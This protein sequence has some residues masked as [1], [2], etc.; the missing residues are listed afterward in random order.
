MYIPT[1]YNNDYLNTMARVCRKLAN[2]QFCKSGST[3][4]QAQKWGKEITAHANKQRYCTFCE[5]RKLVK[6]TAY[7]TRRIRVRGL[8]LFRE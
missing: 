3:V 5:N 6:S 2:L 7:G 1:C 4:L 8:S